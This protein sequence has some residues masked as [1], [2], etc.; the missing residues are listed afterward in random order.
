MKTEPLKI[1]CPHGHPPL[2]YSATGVCVECTEDS[3]KATPWPVQ[4][5]AEAYEARS[6]KYY[7]GKP[8]INGH[9]KQRYVSSGICIGCSSM[10]SGKY[11]KGIRDK[12]R[13][14]S[15][16]FN[17]ETHPDDVKAVRDFVAALKQARALTRGK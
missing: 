1:P 17:V 11:Q 15:V 6:S 2:A 5:R 7:T 8:C 9:V 10:N 3:A 4:T 16:S 13:G 14:D 12:F